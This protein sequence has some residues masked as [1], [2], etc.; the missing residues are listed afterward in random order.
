MKKCKKCGLLLRASEYYRAGNKD[1]RSNTCKECT[2]ARVRANRA[3]KVDHYREYDRARGNHQPPGYMRAYRA[4]NP[5]KYKAQTALN[6][7]VRDGKL[8]KGPCE[9]C[10]STERIHGHHD[11]YSKPLDV[12]WLCPVHHAE[13]HKND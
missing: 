9:K 10:G 11:D 7:A 4:K 2:K 1:G 6:N 5:E 13:A 8:I 3:E 12:R